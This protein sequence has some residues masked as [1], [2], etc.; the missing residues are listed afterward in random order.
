YVA[1]HQGDFETAAT[2]LAKA[3]DQQRGTANLIA[4]ELA[5][6]EL[7]RSRPDNAYTLLEEFLAEHPES[8]KTYAL[9]CDILWEKR[10]FA[11]VREL[12][13]GCGDAIA[14]SVTITI[15]RGETCCKEQKFQE[16]AEMYRDFLDNRSWDDQIARC[17]ANTYEALA[18]P[19]QARDIYAGILST[20]Q[21]CGS[22]PDPFIMQRYAETSFATGDYSTKI[23]E[24][25]LKLNSDDPDNRSHYCRRISEIYRRLDNQVEAERFAALAGG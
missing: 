25:Y 18:E 7:N 16:A 2:E 19:E 22:K 9:M 1:L 4:L 20:C 17:L 11:T 15:L 14:G 24:I 12:L 23:L 3:L 5:T 8:E 6:A 10:E 21:G 13:N